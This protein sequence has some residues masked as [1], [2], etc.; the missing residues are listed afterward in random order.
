MQ[1][2]ERDLRTLV[3][4]IGIADERGVIEELVEGFAAVARVHG[5]VDQLAQV[6]DAREGFG[7][8]FV[9]EEL[10]VACAVDQEL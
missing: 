1:A 8:V 4:V 2:H 9:F 7:C 6:F 3:V 5:G 10:D